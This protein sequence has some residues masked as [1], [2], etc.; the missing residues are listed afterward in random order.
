VKLWMRTIAAVVLV[1]TLGVPL[2]IAGEGYVCATG[3]RMDSSARLAC[4]RC[5]L[6][7]VVLDASARR[8]LAYRSIGRPCCTYVA[9]VGL[10]TATLAGTPSLAAAQISA[11][12]GSAIAL[13]PGM[14]LS[15]APAVPTGGRDLVPHLHQAGPASATRSVNHLRL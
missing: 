7:G 5:A 2:G 12:A 6:R 9:A 1:A 15:L 4:E 8:A 10:P 11:R 14:D 13:A 3:A